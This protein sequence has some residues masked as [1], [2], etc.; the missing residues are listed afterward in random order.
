VVALLPEHAEQVAQVQAV[1]MA[2]G[3]DDDE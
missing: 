1:A 3:S 2:A